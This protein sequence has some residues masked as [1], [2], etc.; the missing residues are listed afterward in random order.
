MIN[1]SDT[2]AA[3][4]RGAFASMIAHELRTPL[5]AAYGALEMMSRAGVTSEPIDARTSL[6]L[7]LAHRNTHRLLRIVEDCLDLEADSD[8]RLILCREDVAPACVAELG[9]Q[10]S[11]DAREQTDVQ[12]EVRGGSSRVVTGDRARLGRALTHLVQN[13][14]SFAPRGTQVSVTISDD[15]SRGMTRFAVQD[16]GAGVDPRLAHE[17]FRRFDC[18]EAIGRRRVGGLG[19]GLAYVRTIAEAHDGRVGAG[20]EPGRTTFWFEVPSTEERTP[21]PG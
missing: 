8:D 11:R 21:H 15:V 17:L 7:D 19:M 12:V 9:I 16:R 13:A 2:D 6:L 5:T 10:G 14:V 3:A 18:R 20:L 1:A 4:R